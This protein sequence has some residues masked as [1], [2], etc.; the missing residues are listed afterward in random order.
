[1]AANRMIRNNPGSVIDIIKMDGI[2][3]NN[4][5]HNHVLDTRF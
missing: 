2:Q 3:K 4:H 1:M 5:G